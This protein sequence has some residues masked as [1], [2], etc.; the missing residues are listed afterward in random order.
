[1]CCQVT[2]ASPF[3]QTA[4]VPFDHLHVLLRHR[5][6]LLWRQREKSRNSNQS[7]FLLEN[8]RLAFCPPPLLFLSQTKEQKRRLCHVW[9]LK[10]PEMI[11]WS[12]AATGEI[13]DKRLMRLKQFSGT[14][15]PR[16]LPITCKWRHFD[17]I[18]SATCLITQHGFG[19]ARYQTSLKCNIFQ[20]K[21]KEINHLIFS[22]V[23]RGQ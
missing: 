3:I 5:A 11:R 13:I 17:F 7:I 4:F 8:K 15:R 14:L 1:M 10:R 2:P 16:L 18:F 23:L 21:T 20:K 19:F 12:R 6:D 22:A 9:S